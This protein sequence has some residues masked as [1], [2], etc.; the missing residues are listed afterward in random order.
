MKK[1]KF[2]LEPVLKV[3]KHKVDNAKNELAK[4]LAEKQKRQNLIDE[5]LNEIKQLQNKGAISDITFLQNRFNRIQLL[6]MN[7]QK[8]QHEIDNIIEI[9]NLRR[10]ELT[11][12]MR[13]EKV[14]EKLKDKKKADYNYKIN[15]EEN[16][17]IDE[18]A[19]RNFKNL[20]Q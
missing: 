2:N 17:F 11:N 9:E 19:S 16:E 20:L 13:D 1:F 7:N 12:L 10:R 6:E 18:I 14:I 5:N 15:K 4:V 3:R 8:I